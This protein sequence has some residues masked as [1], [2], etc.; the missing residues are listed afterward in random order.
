MA[1]RA[2]SSSAANLGG[3]KG[4]SRKDVRRVSSERRVSVAGWGRE[5][6]ERRRGLGG[7]DV[8]SWE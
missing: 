4:A 7:G 6:R 3:E 8:E 5:K 1:G 2:V